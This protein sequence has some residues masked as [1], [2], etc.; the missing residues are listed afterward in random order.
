LIIHQLHYC[1]SVLL[2]LQNANANL[3]W[4]FNLLGASSASGFFFFFSPC[5]TK[6]HLVT[7]TC[8]WA[9]SSE[10]YII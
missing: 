6:T 3:Q 2:L 9:S 4:F 10:D 7:I 1:T 5:L 8:V